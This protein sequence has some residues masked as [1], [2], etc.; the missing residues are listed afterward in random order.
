M[1]NTQLFELLSGFNAYELNRLEKFINSP[2]FNTNSKIIAYFSE[3]LALKENQSEKITAQKIYEKLYPG[4]KY[5][6]GRFRYL[7][8]ELLRL[9]IIFLGQENIKTEPFMFNIAKLNGLIEKKNELLSAKILK[10]CKKELNK[11][12]YPNEHHYYYM[13]LV[14]IMEN[15]I[16]LA[17][18]NSLDPEL[19]NEEAE[20]V[21][22][23][24]VAVV[25]QAALNLNILSKSFNINTASDIVEK[26]LSSI[27]I[28]HILKNK[29]IHNKQNQALAE[30]YYDLLQ[31]ARHNADTGRYFRIK[32][33][34]HS[35]LS[36]LNRQ[37]KYNI[38]TALNSY[39]IQQEIKGLNEFKKERF[40][41]IKL[42]LQLNA[43]SYSDEKFMQPSDFRNNLNI[44][45]LFG[46][47]V[48]A[49]SFIE[50]YAGKLPP[51]QM[52]NTVNL[53]K[54]NLEYSK[55]DY[56]K[57]RKYL[58][59]VKAE[60]LYEKHDIKRLE[61]AICYETG[62]FGAAL[63]ILDAYKHFLNSNKEISKIRKQSV[64]NYLNITKD[65]IKLRLKEGKKSISEI[66]ESVEKTKPLA[67]KSWL[68][69]ILGDIS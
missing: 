35:V 38:I 59:Q 41:L 16:N 30:I 8:S 45:C 39:C 10:E 50:N 58:L 2:Y 29:I 57:A 9:V 36:G 15:H 62:E 69:N 25:I 37:D 3:W 33:S 47:F 66:K 4:E 5:N 21:L 64:W 11:K 24:T 32:S 1:E 42:S 44:S 67:N 65:I 13:L 60:S 56:S 23:L 40:E 54:A 27:D 34:A 20:N 17:F 51:K 31:L 12:R 7:T 48:W 63:E 46:E 61:L 18:K 26:I 68:I 53:A 19:I 22:M 28:E 43:Y 14:L 55:G 49:E 6:D 52:S